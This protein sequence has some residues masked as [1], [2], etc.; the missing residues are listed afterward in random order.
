M[1]FKIVY[2]P[3]HPGRRTGKVSPHA[4]PINENKRD[5]CFKFDLHNF[6]VVFWERLYSSI[7][8]NVFSPKYSCLTGPPWIFG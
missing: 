8:S 2:N 4:Y 1:A 7:S 5:V 6:F 3:T